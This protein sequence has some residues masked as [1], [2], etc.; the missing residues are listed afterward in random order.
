MKVETLVTRFSL[1]IEIESLSLVN[2]P[3]LNYRPTK[4]DDHIHALIRNK[5]KLIR[6]LTP[7]LK[8]HISELKRLRANDP[9]KYSSLIAKYHRPV[10]IQPGKVESFLFGCEQSF[11][12]D[13]DERCTCLCQQDLCT[14]QIWIVSG[15]KL[16]KSNESSSSEAY[17]Y[18]PDNFIFMNRYKKILRK[19]GVITV[20]L[21]KTSYSQHTIVEVVD[22]REDQ[23]SE[24]LPPPEP[25]K[26][27][28]RW[29]W[30]ILIVLI[31]LIV[32][33]LI[34]NRQTADL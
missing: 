29:W 8:E 24:D 23:S 27:G 15:G 30:V 4:M 34:Y 19:G 25:V 6:L 32:F 3:I 5:D 7:D 16:V 10:N 2:A 13:M 22:F 9:F 20:S 1:M 31:I 18:I 17:L 12:G 21:L 33:F 26:D 11:Y 28:F 14:K